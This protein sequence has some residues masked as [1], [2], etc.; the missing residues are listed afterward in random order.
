M[1]TDPPA[2]SGEQHGE[3]TVTLSPPVLQGIQ[4]PTGLNLSAKNKAVNW[5]IYKQQWENYSTVAQLEKQ[6]EEYRVALFL[7]SIG[8]DAMKI[9]NSFDLS[10][11]NRRKLS[12]ILNEF[13]NFATGETNETYINATFSTAMTRKMMNLLMQK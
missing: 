1:P 10:E 3:Q 4:P 11:A 5:K 6:P 12:E 9:Y 2:P 13:D 8:P 7:Y